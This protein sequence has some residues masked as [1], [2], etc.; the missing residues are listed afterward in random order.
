MNNIILSNNNN[1][2]GINYLNLVKKEC[3]LNKFFLKKNE[4]L[5]YLLKII[6]PNLGREFIIKPN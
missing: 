6:L 1:T 4:I 2:T 5:I 3:R